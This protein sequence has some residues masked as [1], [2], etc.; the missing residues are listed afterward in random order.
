MDSYY[1]DYQMGS[2]ALWLLL[3][4]LLFLFWYDNE[5]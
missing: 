3:K 4:L 2:L 1:N 5:E